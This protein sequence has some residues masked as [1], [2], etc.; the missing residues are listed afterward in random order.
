MG[1]YLQ[2]SRSIGDVYLKKPEY[3]REPL[4]SKFRL[5]ETFHKPILSAEPQITEHRIQPNDQFVI[6][7]SDG[8]WEHLSNQEAVDL[9][10]RSPRNVCFLL[11][12]YNFSEL[13]SIFLSRLNTVPSICVF[14]ESILS[15]VVLLLDNNSLRLKDE[16]N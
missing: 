15:Y 5:R 7:A 6:F 13:K 14:D 11:L 2:I 9:V 8:L 16:F 10:Q 4:H 12:R 1:S 3:N